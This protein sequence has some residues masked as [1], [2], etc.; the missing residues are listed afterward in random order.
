M[1]GLILQL[2]T[3]TLIGSTITREPEAGTLSQLLVTPLRQSEIVIGKVLPYLLVS[4]FISASTIAIGHFH[5]G[6]KIH[7]PLQLS[8]ICFFVFAIF[9]RSGTVKLSDLEDSNAGHS[10][11]G[12]SPAFR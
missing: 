3:V 6:I 11:L 7:E 1:V 4:L 2:V 9:A 5:F 8:I 10:V 12:F